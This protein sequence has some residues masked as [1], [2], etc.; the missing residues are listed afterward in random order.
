[1]NPK[2]GKDFFSP[3]K[4]STNINTGFD[5]FVND[6]LIIENNL[7]PI[8]VSGKTTL[9][10]PS[11]KPPKELKTKSF[12]MQIN[13]FS[14]RIFKG[15]Q[16]EVPNPFLNIP[17]SSLPPTINGLSYR[18]SISQYSESDTFP[19]LNK[20]TTA[21][22]SISSSVSTTI[23][24]TVEASSQSDIENDDSFSILND[25]RIDAQVEADMKQKLKGLWKPRKLY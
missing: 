5:S 15:L 8:H 24:S 19:T 21:I 14:T 25:L 2:S 4:N 22:H 11:C 9:K 12:Q 6:D 10:L 3:K 23:S 1:L 20:I 16:E 18:D 7:S 17:K 13:Q